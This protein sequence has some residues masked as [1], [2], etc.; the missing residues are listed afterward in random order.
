MK[1]KI[2]RRFLNFRVVEKN[3]KDKD[4]ASPALIT[5]QAISVREGENGELPQLE[6]Y[7]AL[8]DVDTEIPS[9]LGNF[10]ERIKK[11]AFKRAIRE[12]Q[13]VRALRNHDPDNILGRTSAKTLRLKEDAVGLRIEID[14]PNTSVAR[15]TVES[16]RRGDITGQSFAFIARK[17]TWI[18]GE[19][20]EPDLR[21]I[22]DVDLYD[23][24]PVTYP[25]YPATSIDVNQASEVH[26]EGLRSLGKSVRKRTAAKADLRDDPDP[27]APD[28]AEAPAEPAPAIP[29]EVPEPADSGTE[30]VPATVV[31]VEEPAAAEPE[32]EPVAEQKNCNGKDALALLQITRERNELQIKL[33]TD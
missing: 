29:E 9:W 23:V 24:G 27:E 28:P 33:L 25:A 4:P 15:D 14:P 13:D 20:G 7:A 16:I 22:E 19:D 6:G 10:R 5:R 1:D 11:G 12:G 32:P 31:P 26:E 30:E 3:L 21:I 8:F 18:N 2:E 17:V